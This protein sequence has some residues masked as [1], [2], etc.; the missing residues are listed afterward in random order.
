MQHEKDGQVPL[1][2]LLG[3]AFVRAWCTRETG[4]KELRQIDTREHL[5]DHFFL[6]SFSKQV[7]VRNIPARRCR[8]SRAAWWAPACTSAAQ[9]TS[10][11][12]VLKPPS[13]IITVFLYVYF[14]TFFVLFFSFFFFV[15]VLKFY[16]FI[17][18]FCYS[19]SPQQK[20]KNKL[21]LFLDYFAITYNDCSK[22]LNVFLFYSSTVNEC[23]NKTKDTKF[24][25]TEYEMVRY[26]DEENEE[27][28]FLK[29][30]CTTVVTKQS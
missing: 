15:A 20:K 12:P 9:N 1:S 30:K 4:E 5:W 14:L 16:L 17:W 27:F 6:N 24:Y 3:Q 26:D 19:L 18:F 8:A 28:L 25:F 13:H 11:P 29:I 23:L 7:R 2:L 10:S 22:I 21:S